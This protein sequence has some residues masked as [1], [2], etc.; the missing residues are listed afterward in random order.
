MS[1]HVVNFRHWGR[2]VA[3]ASLIAMAS[4]PSVYGQ[5]ATFSVIAKGQP[6]QWYTG[7]GGP[8]VA[9]GSQ[10]DGDPGQPKTNMD[11]VWSLTDG[12][13][14]IWFGTGAGITA[15]AT[16]ETALLGARAPTPTEQKS[17]GGVLL[18]ALEFGDSTYPNIPDQIR[19]YL[20]DWRPPKFYQLNPT[21]GVV[22]DRT[23]NDSLVQQT[24][25]LRSAGSANNVVLFGG[26]ALLQ[27]GVCMFAFD[28]NTGQYL[29]SRFFPEYSNIRRWVSTP[30]GLY[31][32]VL[33]TQ[34]IT[35]NGSV[36]RW[37]GTRLTPFLF[38][39]VGLLD[40][41]GA[42]MAYHNDRLFVGTW[43]LESALPKFLNADPNFGKFLPTLDAWAPMAGVYMSPTLGPLGLGPLQAPLWKKVWQASDYEPDSIVARGYAMGAMA[44]YGGDLYFGTLHYF[45]SGVAAFT[46]LY[47]YAPP[48]QSGFSSPSE[49]AI[50]IMRAKNLGLSNSNTTP[51]FELLYGNAQQPVFTPDPDT[52]VQG[53]T[54]AMV[55]NK[56][57]AAGLY[58]NSGFGNS[59]N[60]YTWSATV[61]K[62]KLYMGTFD[63][64]TLSLVGRVVDRINQNKT[65]ANDRGCGADLYCFQDGTSAATAVS[66]TG[67]GNFASHGVRNMLAHTTGLYFGMSNGMNLLTN[68][69]DKL[70]EG[71]WELLKL[72]E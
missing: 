63:L 34:P 54:W 40:N 35:S 47:G 49:R 15:Q 21:T 30:A 37:M 16:A 28:A 53:G 65:P 13:S 26:P 43:P 7:L 48:R 51:T 61:Y 22:T 25:G 14:S 4:G 39:T 36:I 12:G 71:G 58:G 42:Y 31:T 33:N 50:I 18:R 1:R 27:A 19:P 45:N 32:S 57:G 8:Y 38:S 10:A 52:T 24:L 2:I 44:S 41:Q 56:Y 29:G 69:T 11:Y 9:M 5:A 55:N 62:N 70:P 67:C 60:T 6:D 23:P 72:N 59:S 20:G 64:G 3:A 17:S 46:A 66:T 68:T